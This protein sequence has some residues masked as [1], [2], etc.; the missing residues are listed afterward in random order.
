MTGQSNGTG[1][2]G[3]RAKRLRSPTEQ[4]EIW[5]ALIRREETIALDAP[6]DRLPVDS[7][8]PAARCH[9]VRGRQ[10]RRHE[11]LEATGQAGAV[12]GERD[13]VDA[14]AVL[15]TAQPPQPG[16]NLQ[17]PTA[18]SQMP[19]DRVVMLPLLAM[20]RGARAR[21]AMQATTTR[22]DGHAEPIGLKLTER[23]RSPSAA[24]ARLLHHIRALPLSV[25]LIALVAGP[26]SAASTVTPVAGEVRALAL[27]GDALVVARTTVR[28]ALV[29]E[30]IVGG[31]PAQTLFS[32]ASS[33]DDDEV[34]LAASA[35]ALAFGLKPEGDEDYPSARVMIGPARG[36]LREVTTCRA[37][38]V[39][40]PV[41]V[42]GSRIAWR[43]GACGEPA[44]G[45]NSVGPSAIVVAGADPA[46][47]VRRASIPGERLPIGL[48]LGA[49]DTG[50]VGTVQPSFFGFDTEVRA[51]SP[52]GLGATIVAERARLVS[53]IGIVANGT[54]VFLQSSLEDEEDC[55]T[56]QLVAIAPA[57][58]D[59][60]IVPIGGCVMA[61]SI[62]GSRGPR[63]PVAVDDRIAAFIGT[64]RDE[65][66][67]L[68][69]VRP[70]GGD[71]RVIVKGT[72]RR[73]EGVAADGA[74]VAWWQP[75][76]AGGEEVVVQ[77]SPEPT[78][79]LAACRAEILTR[80]ARASGGRIALR[81]RCPGGCSGM[82]YGRRIA[83][84]PFSFDAGTHRLSVRLLGRSRS[85][86]VRVE[87]SVDHGP[88]RGATIRVRR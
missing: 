45:P 73:P 6:P 50:L 67:S 80:T 7:R 17:A 15:R 55:D 14:H 69:S 4:Y 74:R 16:V 8:Q 49:G 65:S 40:S 39:V 3:R 22:R 58:S 5:I 68:V 72:Y 23:R 44:A 48:V 59:R 27:S 28:D 79:R 75:R 46:A 21:R 87:L 81:V 26:A 56:K 1:P 11:I 29:L 13:A 31:S 63:T 18:E 9:V 37:G 76:C 10:P 2:S 53:P 78:V 62:L 30:R 24:A 32:A 52:A 66:L 71:R 86:T 33:D 43:E 83:S 36:P 20:A 42:A 12:T 61:P 34:V 64:Q 85:A 70:D 57:S 51:F 47:P 54:R 84:R 35:D 38:L 77:S 82:A 25:A 60:R 88:T 19:P 41:A